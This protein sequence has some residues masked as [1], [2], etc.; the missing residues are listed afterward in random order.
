MKNYK[1]ILVMVVSA[2]LSLM[3]FTGCEKSLMIDFQIGNAWPN[4][5]DK[6][7]VTIINSLNDISDSN[8]KLDKKYDEV[9]FEEQSLF[10]VTFKTRSG[11]GN[12]EKIEVNR[13]GNSVMR[14]IKGNEGMQAAITDHVVVLEVQKNLIV[15]VKKIYFTTNMDKY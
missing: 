10:F 2:I 8:I 3:I 12:I 4:H 13:R 9:F 5:Y 11:G 15:G 1:N 7:I 6:E 14:D